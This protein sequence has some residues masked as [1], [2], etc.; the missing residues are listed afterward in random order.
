MFSEQRFS[1]DVG[2]ARPL[3]AGIVKRSIEDTC[4][5]VGALRG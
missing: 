4:E 5:F 3:T 2:L 1:T